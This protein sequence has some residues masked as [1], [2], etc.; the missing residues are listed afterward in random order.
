MRVSRT[1][2][3]IALLIVS[4]GIV[5]CQSVIQPNAISNSVLPTTSDTIA[6]Q[7][8]LTYQT[9]FLPDRSEKSQV[10][11]TRLIR[12]KDFSTLGL[13]AFVPAAGSDPQ[14]EIVLLK[15]DFDTSNY[16]SVN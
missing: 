13:G 8:A 6:I 10:V 14:L 2:T 15:G 11:F 9:Q 16:C 7:A 12:F 3:A 5:A 1:I 4:M